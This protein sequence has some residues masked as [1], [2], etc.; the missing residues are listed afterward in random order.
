MQT[1]HKQNLIVSKLVAL[2][3][4]NVAARGKVL[5]SMHVQH[6]KITR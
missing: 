1:K 6:K 5:V 2:V 3:L 4:F